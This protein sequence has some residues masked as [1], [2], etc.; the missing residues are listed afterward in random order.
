MS[1]SQ[2]W[3]HFKQSIAT[4]SVKQMPLEEE[5][6]TDFF[7]QNR[8]LS[9]QNKHGSLYSSFSSAKDFVGYYEAATGN[10]FVSKLNSDGSFEKPKTLFA[11]QDVVN[12]KFSLD[13]KLYAVTA[14]SSK[15][16]NKAYEI[17]VCA[18][19]GSGSITLDECNLRDGA[20]INANGSNYLA[21]V[22]LQ[23]QYNS[24]VV[25]RINVS[26]KKRITGLDFI[27][28]IKL[29]KG[30]A[31]Y[32]L[33]D[34]GNG[35]IACVY[36]ESFFQD[37]DRSPTWK[38]AVFENA[39]SNSMNETKCSAI[40]FTANNEG[41]H[42]KF[43][44]S[45]VNEKGNISF[46]FS[47]AKENSF[48]RLGFLCSQGEGNGYS[49]VL[50][51][52]DISGGIYNIACIQQTPSELPKI[53]YNSRLYNRDNIYIL[54]TSSISVTKKQSFICY[55][56][57][58]KLPAE[59]PLDQEFAKKAVPFKPNILKQSFILPVGIVSSQDSDFNSSFI[60]PTLGFMWK[61]Y[62]LWGSKVIS[63]AGAYDLISKTGGFTLGIEGTP[64]ECGTDRLS[65]SEAANV[66]LD[67]NGFAN[68]VNNF[69]MRLQFPSGNISSI[70]VEEKND[71][72]AG[73]EIKHINFEL[74][75]KWVY[76]SE[77]EST[78]DTL[79]AAN[80]IG[81]FFSTKRSA[82]IGYF[83]KK[84]F[85]LGANY[86]VSYKNA[87]GSSFDSSLVYQQ[88]SPVISF[89]IPRLIPVTCKHDYSYNLPL[90][91]DASLYSDKETFLNANAEIIFFAKDMQ[92][93]PK[94]FPF[95]TRRFILYGD[96][97]ANLKQQNGS[98]EILRFADNAR[99]IGSMTFSPGVKLTALFNIK[100]IGLIDNMG[101]NKF[102]ASV[103][104]E[105]KESKYPKF[106]F[107]MN[108]VF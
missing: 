23:S 46:A 80:T 20:I 72:F 101:I 12:V 90:Q 34:G 82:G 5:Y 103:I 107:T 49:S 62:D 104:Y 108:M 105:P 71:I 36:Q 96:F 30:A 102:G 83:E 9:V 65:Y 14:E 6:I 76:Y 45:F 97:Y 1:T 78:A 40:N 94:L 37:N 93:V 100:I 18:T 56:D 89:N 60:I 50:M 106:G 10:Y 21:A 2:A 69:E 17:S 43:L 31:V 24:L 15:G 73:H 22:K 53:V 75:G 28:E 59:N 32:S 81:L 87:F 67:K 99:N 51:E 91:L 11:K 38:I 77:P 57:L 92:F 61:Y 29:P 98:M 19:E 44:T 41:Y 52:T 55:E 8:E 88:V 70:I 54:D 39:C 85:S 13:G 3:E 4:P 79:S 63:T 42:I 27:K 86:S 35:N 66:Y 68:A 48:P 64:S 74:G 84:G 95:F 25:Y 47:W 33:T 16:Y 26:E 58:N 7:T